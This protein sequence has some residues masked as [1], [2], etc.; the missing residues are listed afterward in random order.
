MWTLVGTRDFVPMVT[1]PIVTAMT[2]VAPRLDASD[3]YMTTWT[4]PRDGDEEE[5]DCNRKLRRMHRP[6]E[7]VTS[8]ELIE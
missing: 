6:I 5:D 8:F 2:A 3:A 1:A 4:A 7:N